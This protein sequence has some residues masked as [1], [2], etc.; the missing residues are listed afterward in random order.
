[1][2]NQ[3]KIPA[4]LIA[5][6]KDELLPLRLTDA[7]KEVL[8][9]GRKVRL[10]SKLVKTSPHWGTVWAEFDGLL[11]GFAVSNYAQTISVGDPEDSNENPEVID[12]DVW[13][14]NTAYM[15]GRMVTVCKELIEYPSL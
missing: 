14:F 3:T 11:W 13:S 5:R 7:H 4:K 1:M 10:L 15:E 12:V 8:K 2:K 6:P 9:D